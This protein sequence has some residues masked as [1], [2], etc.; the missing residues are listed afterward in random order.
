MLSG[1]RK[2]LRGVPGSPDGEGLG[3][4][5]GF[6]SFF[7]P[8]AGPGDAGHKL[9]RWEGKHRSH[10]GSSP[11]PTPGAPCVEICTSCGF[12]ARRVRAQ[13]C[14]P[15]CSGRGA[16]PG[17]TMDGE[18]HSGSSGVDVVLLLPSGG[19][20]HQQRYR[21]GVALGEV[22]AT[23]PEFPNAVSEITLLEGHRIVFSP[24][25]LGGDGRSLN[26][27]LMDDGCQDSGVVL[28][29]VFAECAA[30]CPECQSCC[31]DPGRLHFVHSHV[32][33]F[34]ESPDMFDRIHAWDDF[35]VTGPIM[36]YSYHGRCTPDEDEEEACRVRIRGESYDGAYKRLV[37]PPLGVPTV[38]AG[39]PTQP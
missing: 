1:T 30:A 29:T 34:P 36:G 2:N 38:F 18:L 10:F 26:S 11:E 24:D 12:Q 8:R 19:V 14:R 31:S 9:N 16:S 37:D 25:P 32:C 35:F 28:N 5:G 21:R 33:E 27:P 6:R 39:P 20:F 17:G 15:V 3:L 7:G 4:G 23:L 22:I 13:S